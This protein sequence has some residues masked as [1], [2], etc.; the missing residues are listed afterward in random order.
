MATLT[1]AL[2]QRTTPCCA[3]TPPVAASAQLHLPSLDASSTRSPAATTGALGLPLQPS[4]PLHPTCS[5]R[6]LPIQST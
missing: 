5:S 6:L 3:D 1:A 4:Q 2:D